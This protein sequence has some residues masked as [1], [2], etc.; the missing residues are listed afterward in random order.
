[1]H[2][3]A[4]AG[5]PTLGLFGTG[6][7]TVYRPWGARAAYIERRVEETKDDWRGLT[8]EQMAGLAMVNIDVDTVEKA[9]LTLLAK[10][11]LQK[12]AH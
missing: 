11:A 3:S 6:W 5:T 12:T 7:P 1:M 8:F 4:A 10:S 2:L 9:A